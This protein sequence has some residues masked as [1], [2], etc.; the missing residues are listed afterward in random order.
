MR[1]NVVD[2]LC[3]SRLSCTFV[4]ANCYVKAKMNC[5]QVN[6]YPF[7]TRGVTVGHIVNKELGHRF[8][9]M[10]TP[11]IEGYTMFIIL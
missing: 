2:M 10:D 7:T 6:D 5:L 11:G 9:V 1:K 8:Q 4:P 3:L